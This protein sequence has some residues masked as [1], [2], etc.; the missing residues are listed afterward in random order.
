MANTKI[1][2][3]GPRGKVWNVATGCTPKSAG[4]A[5][6]YGKRMSKRLAGRYGYPADKPFRPTTHPDKLAVPLHWKKPS[7]VFVNSMGDL[8]HKDIPDEFIAAV[9]GVM[10]ASP[11][12]FFII[13]TKRPERMRA[14]FEWVESLKWNGPALSCFMSAG[15]K[16]PS[17]PMGLESKTWPLPNVGLGVSV[18]EDKDRHMIDDLLQTPA[19]LRILSAEPLL[20]QLTLDHFGMRGGPPMYLS[21]EIDHPEDNQLDWIISGGESGTGNYIRPCHPEW[22]RKLRDDACRSGTPYFFK[23]WGAWIPEA[24]YD[25]RSALRPLSGDYFPGWSPHDLR[26]VKRHDFDDYQRMYRVGKKKS[27][28]LLDGVEIKQYPAIMEPWL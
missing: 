23:G 25:F 12:H 15:H 11:Q 17:E 28:A 1:E 22:L 24:S 7:I 3:T 8:F 19:A 16:I 5:N 21:S 13:L 6:C 2:W 10:A 27:G 26:N 20:G 18:C 9:F 4:C 14:W